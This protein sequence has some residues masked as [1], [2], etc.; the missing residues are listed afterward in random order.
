MWAIFLFD[1]VMVGYVEVIGG[2]FASTDPAELI[3]AEETCHVVTAAY[4]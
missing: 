4:F 3:L 2:A 1:L